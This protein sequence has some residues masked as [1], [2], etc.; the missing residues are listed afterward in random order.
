[1]LEIT[2][3]PLKGAVYKTAPADAESMFRSLLKMMA[4]GGK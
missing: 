1:M 3:L 2:N 4:G